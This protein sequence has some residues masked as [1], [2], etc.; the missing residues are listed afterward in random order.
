LH[1]PRPADTREL[2]SSGLPAARRGSLEWISI[3]KGVG[4]ILVVIGHFDPIESPRYWL[5]L[6]AVIYSFH[7]PLFFVL[8]GYLYV[9]GKYPYRALVMNKLRRLL[10]PFIT[11]A[12]AYALIKVAAGRFVRLENPV[13]LHSVMAIL[14]DPANS[15]APLLWFLQAL[16]LIFCIYPLLRSYL[17]EASILLLLVVIDEAFGTRYPLLGRVAANMP[18]FVF[19]ILLRQNGRLATT[20]KGRGALLVAACAFVS[21]SALLVRGNAFVVH[22]YL[23]GLVLGLIGT[24]LVISGSRAIAGLAPN[25]TLRRALDEAGYYSMTIYILHAPFEG[26]VRIGFLQLA[27]HVE[28]PFLVVALM[29]VA[30]GVLA[31]IV[32]ERQL[33]RKSPLA[34][35]FVL[36]SQ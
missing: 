36:G 5:D 25:N 23:A 8:S 2:T 11:I 13:D 15:Y 19:G 22:D 31:P 10:Y 12:V 33:I 26:V 3:A 6:R 30:A 1:S 20:V 9:H 7:M 29:A 24:L 28:V 32:V 16:F 4:I 18:F 27:Q 21:G 17:N 35:R 34:R 14:V